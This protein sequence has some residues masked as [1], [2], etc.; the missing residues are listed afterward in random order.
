MS[1]GD[2]WNIYNGAVATLA[3]GFAG[4]WFAY[5]L[6]AWHREKDSADQT[7]GHLN[8]SIAIIVQQWNIANFIRRQVVDPTRGQPSAWLNM[9]SVVPGQHKIVSHKPDAIAQLIGLKQSHLYQRLIHTEGALFGALQ[10]IE[11]FSKTNLEIVWPVLTKFGIRIGMPSQMT[12]D[13][14][15]QLLGGNTVH[16]QK[17]LVL[18]IAEDID[19]VEEELRTLVEQVRGVLLFNF[20]TREP[21]DVEY[22]SK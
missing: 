6:E 5:K 17:M 12:E 14:L 9:Q 8:E 16:Q 7:F 20:P 19:K 11:V 18:S 13:E 10:R 22:L 1:E 3:A 2:F 4:P 21:M 15:I